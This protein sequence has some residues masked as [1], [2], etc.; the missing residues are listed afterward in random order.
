MANKSKKRQ[1]IG[2]M[3]QSRGVM[4]PPTVADVVRKKKNN[5]KEVRQRLRKGDYDV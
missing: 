2:K 1:T 5:R 3:T 4:P